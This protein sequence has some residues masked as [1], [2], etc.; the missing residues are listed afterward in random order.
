MRVCAFM[1]CGGANRIQL[2]EIY[3]DNAWTRLCAVS[4]VD[5]VAQSFIDKYSYG[6]RC[7]LRVL[8]RF[9]T[10]RVNEKTREST[11]AVTSCQA[12]AATQ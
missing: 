4:C 5:E 8:I 6:G 1:M 11:P 10:T 7:I 9:R 2:L 3:I 12:I